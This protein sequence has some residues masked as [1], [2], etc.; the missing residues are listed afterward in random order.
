MPENLGAAIRLAFSATCVQLFALLGLE[1]WPLALPDGWLYAKLH[2]GFYAFYG[3]GISLQKLVTPS[4][5]W[6]SEST[7]G[8]YISIGL[9][10]ALYGVILGAV[11]FTFRKMRESR[12]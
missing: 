10:M 9:A 5:W 1:L 11:F 3:P 4:S 7:L 2:D 6:L 12:A 8:G